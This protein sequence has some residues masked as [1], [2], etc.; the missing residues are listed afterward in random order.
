MIRKH[1]KYF[2]MREMSLRDIQEVS[3]DILKDVHAFCVKHN[4]NYTLFGGSMIGAIRHGAIIPW[5]DDIDIAMPRPDYERFIHEYVSAS[6]YKLFAPELHNCFLGF[7]R[8]SEM[9][10]TYVNC[11]RLKWTNEI[12]GCWI[13]IFPLDAAPDNEKDLELAISNCTKWWKSTNAYRYSLA[14]RP[15]L[16][17]IYRKI[18]RGFPYILKGGPMGY[19]AEC[20]KNVM[21]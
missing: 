7:A 16:R 4:I 11:G 1:K 21:G 8:V 6:G 2:T 18:F 10:K 9:K 19:V 20:K 13:D 14:N 15:F 17:Q 5:D 3:L 12:T